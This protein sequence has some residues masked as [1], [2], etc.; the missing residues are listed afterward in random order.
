VI[1][2]AS[3]QQVAIPAGFGGEAAV[4]RP[5]V[6]ASIHTALAGVTPEQIASQRSRWTADDR[7]VVFGSIGRFVPEKGMDLLIRSFRA[8]FPHGGEPV[9]L[10]VLGAGPQREELGRLAVG[11]DRITL[12]STRS[13][14]APFYRAFDI[15]V[16]AARFEPFGLTILEAMDAACSLVV[17]RTDGPREFLENMRVLWAE[18]DDE[19][20]LAGQLRVAAARGRMPVDFD[21]SKFSQTN[22]VTAIEQFYQRVLARGSFEGRKA[23]V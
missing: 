15:Y 1:C 18:P 11:D 22:A 5:W 4:V 3:W 19:A 23:A 12:M 13:E 16:S 21:R 20:S 17:T 7:T 9:R 8:A 2:T 10:V 14:I 6:S